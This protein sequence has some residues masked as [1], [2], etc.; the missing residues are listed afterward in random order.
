MPCIDPVDPAWILF[1]SL[2]T[3]AIVA[4]VQ[5]NIT[6]PRCETKC[7]VG[8]GV[9]HPEQS[10]KNGNSE[11]VYN[12]LSCSSIMS[13]M[14]AESMKFTFSSCMTIPLKTSVLVYV[15]QNPRTQTCDYRYSAQDFVLNDGPSE[16]KETDHNEI[17]YQ[18]SAGLIS[19]SMVAGIFVMMATFIICRCHK[20]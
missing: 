15:D 19:I 12:I 17:W 18:A 8:E 13:D 6:T 11:F 14:L 4:T 7:I 2:L 20:R 1:I 5:G 10:C 3:M 16:K 9:L